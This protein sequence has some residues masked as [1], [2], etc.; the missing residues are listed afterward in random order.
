VFA[1]FLIFVAGR[2]AA[3]IH[4]QTNQPADFAP[5]A[6]KEFLAAEARFRSETA[7][8]TAAWEF[9]RAAFDWGEFAGN[10][11]QRAAIAE[12]GIA[13]CRAAV[14]RAPTNA[15]GHYYLALNIGRLADTKRNLSALKL[16]DDMERELKLAAGLEPGFDHA[17]PDRSL[18]MLYYEAPGWPASIGSKTKARAHLQRALELS[19]AYPENHLN[20]LEA[21]LKWN[22]KKNLPAGLKACEAA[23]PAARTN[24]TGE[25]WASSWAE[26][27]KR[28]RLIQKKAG[29]VL[30]PKK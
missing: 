29:E 9:G 21:L 3:P 8:T 5:R 17:G 26:W 19:P 25:A 23:L 6:H 12:T 1:A 22:D 15:A 18:G 4:A 10:N 20:W 13:A 11:T 27:D 2:P 28:W 16:V 7:N 30:P 24:L 14:G